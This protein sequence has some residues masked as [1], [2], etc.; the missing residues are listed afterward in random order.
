MNNNRNP[1][2]RSESPLPD[3]IFGSI[4]IAGLLALLALAAVDLEMHGLEREQTNKEQL[5]GCVK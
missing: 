2:D 4:I 5:T 3:G 1:Y